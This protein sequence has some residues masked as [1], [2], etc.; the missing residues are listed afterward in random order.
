M[1]ERVLGLGEERGGVEELR[2]HERA[3]RR[4]EVGL[5]EPGHAAEEALAELLPDHRR[6]LQD[7]L[8]ALAE[9]IDA[10]RE[11]RLDGRRHGDC[12]DRPREPIRP[13]RP[14]EAASL[15]ERA[16]HLLDEE[17]VAAGARADLR[18]Q[19]PE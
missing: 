14:G 7:T 2:R 13:P 6:R 12:L 3:Q 15:L 8:L 19:L 10:R 16:N 1:S 5:G 11:H 17:R 18:R 9:P 4:G